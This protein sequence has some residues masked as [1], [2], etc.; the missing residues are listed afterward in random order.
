[1]RAINLASGNILT[2]RYD[3]HRVI[4]DEE[5]R[6]WAIEEFEANEYY[7]ELY[8]LDGY[9]KLRAKDDYDETIADMT[10]DLYR[11]C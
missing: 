5:L 7:Q 11:A 10:S 4:S 1:M 3:D 2:L 8:T 6:E 9:I